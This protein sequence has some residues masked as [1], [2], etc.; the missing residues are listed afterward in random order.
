MFSKYVTVDGVAVNYFH[1]G[2]STLPD[3]TPALD[4]GE[5]LLFLHGAGSNAHTWHRQLEHFQQRH[6]ALAVDLPAH[7]RSGSIEGLPDL[8]AHVR[9]TAAY[10][11]AL[12]LR[13][14]VLVGRALGGAVAIAFALAHPAQVRALVLVATPARFVMPPASLDTWRAVTMGRATQ[15]FSTALFSPKAD[16]AVMRECFMEQ[17]KTD[18][19]VRYTDML[20]CDGVDFSQRLA[21]LSVPTLV[22]TGR[23]DHFA[24]P[25]QA[26]KVRRGIAGAQLTVVDDAGH[27]LTSEQP[28]A[29]NRAV[30]AF[31]EALPR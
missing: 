21:E 17:V 16:M 23:D 14:C 9:F 11:D 27:M 6:S 24:P 26:E 10:A 31:V 3:V 5:L 1:T 22:I 19:R 28:D 2:R 4:Q 20:A 13:P 8:D 30:E 12:A 7:G 15:P 18:P 25:E 29:F